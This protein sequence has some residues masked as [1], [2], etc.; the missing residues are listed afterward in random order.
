MKSI[1]FLKEKLS[2]I[3]NTHSY[4]EIQ[5][6]YRSQIKT[7]I[8]EVK[9]AHCF[10]S[11]KKYIDQQISLENSF[12]ELFHNEEIL[13][14]TENEL[15]QID[16][17]ILKLGVSE[18]NVN[19]E[20][21][22]LKELD[23]LIENIPFQDYNFIDCT[24]YKNPIPEIEQNCVYDFREM[25]NGSDFLTSLKKFIRQPILKKKKKDSETKSESFFFI[26]IV[27]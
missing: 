4:L 7:H 21:L 6:E 2:D 14:I 5:Y 3:F 23:V 17:P 8:I 1:I 18:I 12:E 26:N 27:A 9:P 16:Q 22:T 24:L 13:F 19:Q 10:E 25:D 15:I 11:D 20:I